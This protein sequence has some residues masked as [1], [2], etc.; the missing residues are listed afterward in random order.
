MI[1]APLEQIVGSKCH[2]FICST[3]EGRCPI[4]D[5]G[6]KNDS[7]ERMLVT[8]S[9]EKVPIHKSVIPLTLDDRK[10]SI[11]CF[12]DISEQKQAEQERIKKEKLQGVIE[13]AGAVCHELNQPMQVVLGISELLP[14]DLDD[15]HFNGDIKEIGFITHN[16]HKSRSLI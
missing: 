9:G 14:D 11:E 10:C 15:H 5:F 6:Q 4:T 12:V 2:Q 8:A 16:S 1:G 7:S 13:M 3:E